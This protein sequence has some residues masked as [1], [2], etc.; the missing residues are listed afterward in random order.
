VFVLVVGDE[1][2]EVKRTADAVSLRG[3]QAIQG[4]GRENPNILR[5]LRNSRSSSILSV[6]IVVPELD[7]ESQV[8]WFCWFREHAPKNVVLTWRLFPNGETTVRVYV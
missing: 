1:P 2:A 6:V 8:N 4:L 5:L 7:N 3:V